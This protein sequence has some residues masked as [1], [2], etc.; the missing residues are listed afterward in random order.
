MCL[1][2]QNERLVKCGRAIS[3]FFSFTLLVA[4]AIVADSVFAWRWHLKPTV[5]VL[6]YLWRYRLQAEYSSVTIIAIAISM[7]VPLLMK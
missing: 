3:F 4:G 1:T 6:N 2:N 7:T 5:F